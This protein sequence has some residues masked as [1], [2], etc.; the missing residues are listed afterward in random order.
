M[1]PDFSKIIDRH[2]K[3]VGDISRLHVEV[4]GK[5]VMITSANSTGVIFKSRHEC[6][7]RPMSICVDG[8]VLQSFCKASDKSMTMTSE[9]NS[10]V[11]ATKKSRM[12]I[13]LIQSSAIPEMPAEAKGSMLSEKD[14]QWIAEA[15][16]KV[17]L[18]S[19][20]EDAALSIA[21]GEGKLIVCYYDNFHGAFTST[22]SNLQFSIGF[23]P[24]D[25]DRLR[26][27]IASSDKIK[28]S[29]G[30]SNVIIRNANETLCIPGTASSAVDPSQ[31]RASA[32][33][34]AK[35]SLDSLNSMVASVLPHIPDGVISLSITR[36]KIIAAANSGG[37][38]INA[39]QEILGRSVKPLNVNLSVK[40]LADLLTLC[41]G[42]GDLSAHYEGDTPVRV[43]F[44]ANGVVYLL[45]TSE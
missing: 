38:F 3:L 44:V 43:Q 26:A 14:S 13:P 35:L 29:A 10:L 32:K 21:A 9:K 25:I 45:V 6:D 30:A 28:F 5:E 11:I 31:V 2:S 39:K 34:V 12:E 8:A 24:A 40:F 36:D 7:L 41:S 16:A 33:L 42:T 19:V 17:K 18:K 37:K 27:M 1:K 23:F 22:N 20:V 4:I 15:I